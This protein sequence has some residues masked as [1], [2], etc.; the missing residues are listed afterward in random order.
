MRHLHSGRKLNCD[1]SHRK[2]MLRS[3]TLALIENEAIQTIPTR[4]KELRWW[5]DRV[6]TLAKRGDLASRRQIIQL[7]GSTETHRPGENRVRMAIE[8]VYSE[9]CPRFKDR[10]GGYTQILRLAKRRAGDNADQCLMRYIP[11][12]DKKKS[13]GAKD[14]KAKTKAPKKEVKTAKAEVAPKEEKVAK[15]SAEPQDKPAKAPKKKE[16]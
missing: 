12:E 1:S 5:A 7:L 16:K 2:A 14:A 9:L 13:E 4:A 3:M 8:K 6:V 11:S 10:N 15:K